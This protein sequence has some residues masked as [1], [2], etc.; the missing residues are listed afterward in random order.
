MEVSEVCINPL[1]LPLHKRTLSPQGVWSLS[2]TAVTPRPLLPPP[3]T[4]QTQRDVGH[5]LMLT[6]TLLNKCIKRTQVLII[7]L[8]HGITRGDAHK[9]HQSF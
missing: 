9:G 1:C 8:C 2:I 6:R 5:T 4:R 7:L 3:L